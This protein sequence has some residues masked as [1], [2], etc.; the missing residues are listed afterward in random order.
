MSDAAYARAIIA[1]GSKSF[2][3]AS[4]LLPN[5][6]RDDVARLYAWCRT[7]DDLID[8]Q[9]MGHGEAVV[10]DAPARL[11]ALRTAT[12]EALAG[13]ASDP[14]FAG[15]GEVAERYAIPPGLAHDHLDGFAM[16]VDGR[17]YGTED[18]LARYC[19]GVAGSVGVMMA[20]VMGVPRE[21][22]DTLDR[23]SDLGL[24]FQLTNIARDV[25]ADARS[26]RVYLPASA[27]EAEG[28]AATAAAVADPMNR[29]AVWRVTDA[30]VGSADRYYASADVGIARLPYRTAWAIA[31][32]RAVY[33]AIGLRRR[34]A[35]PD[36]LSVRVGTGRA[37][38]VALIARS[39]AVAALPE[40][41]PSG[42]R[43]GL[44]TRPRHA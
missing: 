36:G 1:L 24:A 35:G 42:A 2:A 4:R 16:D 7:A 13:R 34:A 8:G 23:A 11:D 37:A 26:G 40:R 3:A 17:I 5:H 32:A 27:L 20:L 38:K 28:L 25:I 21:A 44:W 15:F 14:I 30:L 31:S 29:A 33:R 10:D 43:D 41:G 6:V 18:E 39:S 22:A 12:N 19:Y 9:V